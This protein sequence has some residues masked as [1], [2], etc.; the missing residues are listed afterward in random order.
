VHCFV[1]TIHVPAF[2]ETGS[3]CWNNA[4]PWSSLGCDGLHFEMFTALVLL[5]SLQVV[6]LIPAACKSRL[7]SRIILL[8]LDFTFNLFWLLQVLKP[9]SYWRD[10]CRHWMQDTLMPSLSSDCRSACSAVQHSKPLFWAL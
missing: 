10:T 8:N 5:D 4:P 2:L 7:V 1:P 9:H 6:N 3:Q